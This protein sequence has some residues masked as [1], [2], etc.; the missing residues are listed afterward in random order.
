MFRWFSN[1]RMKPKLI[2][3]FLLVGVLP[4]A[5]CAWFSYGGANDSLQDAEA[6]SA[7]ALKKQTFDQ[8]VALRDVKKS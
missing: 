8:L 2:S 3:L 6:E 5:V 7:E 1:V 4:L